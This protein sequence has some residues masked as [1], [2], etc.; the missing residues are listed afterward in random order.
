MPTYDYKLVRLPTI[1]GIEKDFFGI[2]YFSENGE[3][4]FVVLTP[5]IIKNNPFRSIR[6]KEWGK[7]SYESDIEII[8]NI[9][10]LP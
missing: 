1:K 3:F 10:S 8:G 6:P 5:E 7:Q 4:V 2:G 9:K